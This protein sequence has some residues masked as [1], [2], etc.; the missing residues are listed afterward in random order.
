MATYSIV[1]PAMICHRPS[2]L[3]QTRMNLIVQVNCGPS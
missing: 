2:R 1:E 3:S